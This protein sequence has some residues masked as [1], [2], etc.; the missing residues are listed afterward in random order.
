MQTEPSERLEHVDKAIDIALRIGFIG[1]LFA[2][3]FLILRPF[4][5]PVVWGLIIAVATYPLHQKLTSIFKGRTKLSAFIIAL[6]GLSV[7]L[8]PSVIFTNSTVDTVKSIAQ[9][10]ESDAL[11]I[12]MPNEKVKE[13]PIFGN[14]IYTIWE[15][16]NQNIAKTIKRFGPQI[17]TLIPMITGSLTSFVKSFFMFIISIIIAAA[18]LLVAEPG[19]KMADVVY[20]TLAGNKA[21]DLSQLSVATI[22][23]VVQ[24]IVGTAFIQT[25][26]LSIGLFAVDVPA[27]GIIAIIILILAIVQIPVIIVLLPVVI[28]VFS[29]ESTTIA[30]IFMIWSIIGSLADNV[31]KPMLM[32]KGVDVPMLVILIG[33]LGGMILVGPLGL[34]IGAVILAIT[35]KI[36][37]TLVEDKEAQ[38][39]NRIKI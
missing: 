18:L 30:V 4:L 12:P 16:T 3:S 22:R 9:S 38:E 14:E 21:E 33:A 17:K 35:Y 34:F 7:I 28:Y 39:S 25:A 15:Q 29:V 5:A 2:L 1:L 26:I 20:K 10:I 31:L 13:W 23:N 37:I 36:L 11:E 8:V 19:K 6:L 32:G 27:A 24:G